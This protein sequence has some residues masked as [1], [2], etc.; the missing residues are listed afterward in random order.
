LRKN[1]VITEKD[2]TIFKSYQEKLLPFLGDV[3]K[4]SNVD[5]VLDKK[6]EV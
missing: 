5:L 6:K 1:G 4:G 3:I 2:K